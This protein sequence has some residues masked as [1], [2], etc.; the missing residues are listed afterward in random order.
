MNLLIE[1][2]SWWANNDQRPNNCCSFFLEISKG[3]AKKHFSYM[4]IALS[5]VN[6]IHLVCD[7]CSP[8]SVL[9]IE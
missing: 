7:K 6:G 1:D 8:Q 3:L 5:T 9:H 2:F 4:R